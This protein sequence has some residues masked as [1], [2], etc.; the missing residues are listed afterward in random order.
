MHRGVVLCEVS[1]T[2]GTS[3]CAGPPASRGRAARPPVRPCRRNAG[4]AKLLAVLN[5]IAVPVV[6]VTDFDLLRDWATLKQIYELLGG[7]ADA[8]KADW[9]ATNDLLKSQRRPRSLE[10]IAREVSEAFTKFVDAEVGPGD[11]EWPLTWEPSSSVR[12]GGR[13]PGSRH[14][15]GS[16]ADTHHGRASAG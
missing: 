1:P 3:R 7:D 5:A 10:D 15:G 8:I 9:R 16:R 2:V 6:V 13:K 14:N 11:K 4:I 12:M